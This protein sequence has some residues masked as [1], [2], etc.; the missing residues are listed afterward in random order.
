MVGQQVE[1]E[2]QQPALSRVPDQ[3]WLSGVVQPAPAQNLMQV[4][5]Q[6]QGMVQPP[7]A[8][9]PGPSGVS[10]GACADAGSGAWV[11]DGSP[12]RAMVPVPSVSSRHAQCRYISCSL[13]LVTDPVPA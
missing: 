12:F 1:E 5:V 6:V 10:A 13:G 9:H 8:V 4:P 3:T 2:A 11:G 7:G